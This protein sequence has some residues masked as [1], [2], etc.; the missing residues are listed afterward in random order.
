[1]IYA[2]AVVACAAMGSTLFLALVAGGDSAL[3][4]RPP[5]GWPWYIW[6]TF[7]GVDVAALTIILLQL[8]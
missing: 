7:A 5:L 4:N 2:A 1:M 6:L 8:S 3:G